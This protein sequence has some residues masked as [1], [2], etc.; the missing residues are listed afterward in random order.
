MHMF[1]YKRVVICALL[2][3]SLSSCL[4]VDCEKELDVMSQEVVSLIEKSSD[5]FKGVVVGIDYLRG[6]I[7]C[8]ED[9]AKVVIRHCRVSLKLRQILSTYTLLK[10]VCAD[11]QAAA[12][13][14]KASALLNLAAASTGG[15]ASVFSSSLVTGLQIFASQ[16]AQ[17]GLPI[18]SLGFG[19]ISAVFWAV[20]AVKNYEKAKAN[21]V[22]YQSRLEMFE[23]LLR[24]TP[25]LSE[26]EEGCQN[27]VMDKLFLKTVEGDCEGYKRLLWV[28]T[29]NL[30]GYPAMP[31]F[32]FTDCYNTNEITQL[33][34]DKSV[35]DILVF[36]KKLEDILREFRSVSNGLTI[37]QLFWRTI[38]RHFRLFAVEHITF[39]P[40]TD[41]SCV[42]PRFIHYKSSHKDVTYQ[43]CRGRV[44]WS[45]HTPH[46]VRK[47]IQRNPTA[48][49]K[50]WNVEE[51]KTASDWEMV[52]H[53]GE[54][55]TLTFTIDEYSRAFQR[56]GLPWDK[57]CAPSTNALPID[58]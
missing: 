2:L 24:S 11:I 20:D 15:G 45:A 53:M 25:L 35:A 51:L 38:L 4:A 30:A 27:G 54:A 3:V 50:C 44:K 36:E 19:V 46:G 12:E 31:F 7:A 8:G 49:P 33:L 1:N 57:D 58:D 42:D 29:C 16:V 5:T 26:M 52:G 43:A 14:S 28:R 56:S 40:S 9:A 32:P 18:I 13:N 37:Y 39:I 22:V 17:L 41:L 23:T 48:S 47:F 6:I 55:S 21:T 10:V 34:R